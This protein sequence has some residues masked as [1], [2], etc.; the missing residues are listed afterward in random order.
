MQ[1]HTCIYIHTILEAYYHV[2]V[3]LLIINYLQSQFH[4]ENRY[5]KSARYHQVPTIVLTVL[6][7]NSACNQGINRYDI[8]TCTGHQKRDK[9]RVGDV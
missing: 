9:C 4:F 8:G 3:A 7:I 5:Y 2:P 1:T 6:I